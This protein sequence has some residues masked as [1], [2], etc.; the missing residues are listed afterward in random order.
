MSHELRTP[1]NSLLILSDQLCKNREGNLHARQIE[2][3]RTIHASGNDLL[4]LINDILDLAKIESGT[5]VV[6]L[7]ELSLRELHVYVERTFR[8]VAEAKNVEFSIAIDDDAGSSLVTDSKRFA[9][10]SQEPSVKRL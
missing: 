4:T 3:A 10:N 6:D 8:Y 2:F 1:L 9:A 5:V 7:T